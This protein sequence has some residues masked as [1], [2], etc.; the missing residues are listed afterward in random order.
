[1]EMRR[2]YAHPAAAVVGLLLL[3]TFEYLPAIASGEFVY[4]DQSAIL[5]TVVNVQA[6]IAPLHTRALTRLSYRLDNRMGHGNPWA[7]HLTNVVLHLANGLLVWVLARWLALDARG[8]LM[9]A[10]CFLLHPLQTEA[11][12][13]GAGRTEVLSTLLVLTSCLLAWRHHYVW[14]GL[15]AALAVS[16]KESAVVAIG[17]WL[18][19]VV[20]FDA[21]AVVRR[22]LR[23]TLAGLVAVAL[24]M[25]AIV[26]RVDHYAQ[27]ELSRLDYAAL[28]ATAFWRYVWLLVWPV[29]QSVDHD[30]TSTSRAVGYLALATWA[31]VA[32]VLGLLALAW[33]TRETRE[34][35]WAATFPIVTFAGVWVW[36]TIAPRFIM[37]IPE[38]LNEHQMYLPMVGLS[39]LVGYALEDRDVVVALP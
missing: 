10:A 36:V 35:M 25:T 32:L 34:P 31:W 16:A 1:M 5:Q 8:A 23:W 38:V 33:T 3:A 7:F 37:R 14:A 2:V 26:L 15:C 21:R 29:G 11:V 17:C 13:Y 22:D 4:E 28:Q 19:Y 24:G 18:A 12:A 6:P 9:A 20:L 30:L 27:A 39:L